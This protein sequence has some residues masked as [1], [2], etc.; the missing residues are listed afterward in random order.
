MCPFSDKVGKHTTHNTH[1]IG[2]QH[3]LDEHQDK[4]DIRS[5]KIW[6]SAHSFYWAKNL[7]NEDDRNGKLDILT[8]LLRDL[9]IPKSQTLQE[10][11]VRINRKTYVEDSHT[12]GCDIERSNSSSLIL[13]PS[14]SE[15]GKIRPH[16]IIES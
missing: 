8:K 7:P 6:G 4:A 15:N 13:W 12:I 1:P 11:C 3:L 10:S 14:I 5:G 2:F 9:S 16:V